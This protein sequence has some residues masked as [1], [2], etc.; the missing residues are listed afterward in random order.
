MTAG[1][2]VRSQPQH[3]PA[4]ANW[5]GTLTALIFSGSAEDRMLTARHETVFTAALILITFSYMIY[6]KPEGATGRTG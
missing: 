3:R 4:D 2:K 6:A 1:W 5:A